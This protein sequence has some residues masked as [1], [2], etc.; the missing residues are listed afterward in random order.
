MPSNQ[1]PDLVHRS[2]KT[3]SS[4]TSRAYYKSVT[5]STRSRSERFFALVSFFFY[6]AHASPGVVLSHDYFQRFFIILEEKTFLRRA[7]LCSRTTVQKCDGSP[8]NASRD[9]RHR[10]ILL[11]KDHSK[12]SPNNVSR[13][14]RTILLKSLL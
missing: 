11:F 14:Q 13:D 7:P 5:Y 8:F 12:Y 3:G 4:N 9:S 2:E 1:F 10:E 6:R